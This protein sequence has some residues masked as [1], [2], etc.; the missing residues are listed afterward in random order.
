MACLVNNHLSYKRKDG[1]ISRETGNLHYLCKHYTTEKRVH[2]TY[3]D[4]K[5]RTAMY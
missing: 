4:R 1:K 5:T 2:A 3:P